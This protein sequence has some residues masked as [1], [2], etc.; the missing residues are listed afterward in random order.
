MDCLSIGRTSDFERLF[1]QH[2]REL[3]AL[4]SRVVKC[5]RRAEDIVHD[6][7]LK[8]YE[9]TSRSEI[10]EPR[11]YLFGM[12]RNHAI[13]WVRRASLESRYCGGSEEEGMRVS[14]ALNCP[15][16]MLQC[17]QALS[18]VDTALKHL[19]KRTRR[20]FE[21]HRI[22]GIPQN[23]IATEIAVSPTLVNFMVRDAHRACLAAVTL[24]D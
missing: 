10:R 6:V 13:D 15:E 17:Q 1:I 9:L 16:K 24:L 4:A 11:H 12:V 5:R 19:P 14:C 20:V 7:F 8:Y 22:E 21:L 23:E 18:A 2:R 3:I